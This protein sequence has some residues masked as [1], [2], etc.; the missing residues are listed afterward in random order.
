[1]EKLMMIQ[2]VAEVTQLKLA[3]IR[4][5]ISLEKIPFVRLGKS[6]RFRPSEIE[7]WIEGGSRPSNE[8]KEEPDER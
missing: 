2:E 7:A 3:T 8:K 6:I 4:K 1:M 5:Y